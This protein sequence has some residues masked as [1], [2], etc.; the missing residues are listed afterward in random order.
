[1]LQSAHLPLAV[2]L[3]IAAPSLA[4]QPS[5]D[6]ASV[7]LTDPAASPASWGTTGGPGT[8]DP[9]RIHF[10][11]V[12]MLMLLTRAFGVRNDQISAPAWARNVMDGPFYEIEATM[13]PGTTKEQFQSMLQ[14]LLAERF[15]LVFHHETR[16]FPGYQLVVAKGGPKLKEVTPDPQA[17]AAAATQRPTIGKDGSIVMPP[18]PRTF[19]RTSP[20]GERV[21]YQE[22]S[23]AD[24]ATNLGAYVSQERGADFMADA[25]APRARVVDKT[26]LAGK[27][28]FTLEFSCFGCRGLSLMAAN[29]PVLAAARAQAEASPTPAA[30]EPEGGGLPGIFVALEKQL[31]L[32]LEKVKDVPVDVIVIDRVDKVPIEN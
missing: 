20:G 13:P 5:F 24:L 16:N 28:D 2:V 7:K 27:Y 32:K 25:T 10:G 23:I 19:T 12:P 14:N 31:G 26:G 18:G 17:N 15:H 8:T 29:L 1:M 11:R 4:Q 30:S 9:G 3:L 22:R 6:A 21:Q